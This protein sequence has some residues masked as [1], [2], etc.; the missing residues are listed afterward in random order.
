[1]LISLRAVPPVVYETRRR[2]LDALAEGPV[3]GPALAD[4]LD[5]SRAAVWKHVETLREEGFDVESTDAGYHV[6]GTPE[7]GAGAVEF[8]L[9]A[10]YTVEY[11]DTL[12]NTNARA[13]ELATEGGT[14]VAVLAAEQTGGRGRLDRDWDSPR[15]GVYLSLLVRPGLA[16]AAVPVLTLAAAVATVRAA[17]AAGVEAGIKW[18]NDVL[19]GPDEA[20]LAGILTEMTGEAD[21]VNWVVVG[22]GANADVPAERLPEGATS[23]RTLGGDSDRLGF[24]R[25]FLESFAA[26]GADP[27][28]VL[29]A[30]REHAL[31]LGRRVRIE[32][33]G[34][35]VEG[36]AVD[37]E[38]PGSLVVET[39]TGR[40]TVT[41]GDCE[42]LRPA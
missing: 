20:K 27:E 38:P 35:V 40:Q 10:P 6:V 21:R 33:P 37:V 29:P 22:V 28:A 32:T 31:T 17:T 30:W 3:P 7:Y 1:V 8:G 9:E 5:V 16:P 19:A 23:L 34:G 11:H 26:L 13:R 41:A 24:V 36:T 15:G 14:D 4:R 12:P 18:P 25:T 39:A 42:H 2:I